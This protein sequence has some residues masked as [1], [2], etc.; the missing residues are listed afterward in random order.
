MNNIFAKALTDGLN[1]GY[2]GGK[3]E[4]VVRSGFE[5]NK[6][7]IELADGAIYHDEWFVETR[8]GGGQELVQTN[9]GK[10]TR[11]YAGGTPDETML[12]SLGITVKDVG[13]YL[14]EKILELGDKTRLF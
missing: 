14:K 2:A 5:G 1:K 8:L 13:G 12:E 7:Y 4:S 9:E 6:S 3:P 11:L 10:F